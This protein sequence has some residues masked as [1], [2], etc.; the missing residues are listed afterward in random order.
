[1]LYLGQHGIGTDLQF[2]VGGI[3]ITTG[4]SQAGDCDKEYSEAR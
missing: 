1:L 4:E 3:I 2:R